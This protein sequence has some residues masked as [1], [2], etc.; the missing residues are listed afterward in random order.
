MSALQ[1]PPFKH[2]Q[3]D[4][5]PNLPLKYCL[6]P[7]SHIYNRTHK[8][9][10]PET[11][12]KHSARK[13]SA[14]PP[15]PGL[16][17]TTCRVTNAK[18]SD[19]AFNK[20]VNTV[21]IPHS[22]SLTNGPRAIFRFKNLDPKNAPFPYL[23]LA[24][25]PDASAPPETDAVHKSEGDDDLVPD[26]E[27]YRESTEWDVRF[28]TKIETLGPTPTP[29]TTTTMTTQDPRI[30]GKLIAVALEPGATAADAWLDAKHMDMLR[31]QA[32]Y[33]RSHGYVLDESK[34]AAWRREG[35]EEGKVPKFMA[36][37]EFTGEAEIPA[38]HIEFRGP[39]E[40]RP[41]F[42]EAEVVERDVWELMYEAGDGEVRL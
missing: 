3:S 36:L 31:G 38:Q 27:S 33:L 12:Q 25:L 42:R 22:L 14:M 32:G 17:F 20:W 37:H 8:E 39:D 6:H 40:K 13:K 19:A 2:P 1:I 10:V 18:W 23:S 11:C 5:N 28:Y 34:T 29:T 15:T 21:Q 26:G 24:V 41:I 35:A 7:P 4:R 30:G 16:I 9:M